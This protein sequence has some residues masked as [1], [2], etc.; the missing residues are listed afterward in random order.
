MLNDENVIFIWVIRIN[1]ALEVNAAIG[2]SEI[3][4]KF[5]KIDMIINVIKI[6]KTIIRIIF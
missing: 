5:Q 1:P 2:F 4:P 3:D 6:Y